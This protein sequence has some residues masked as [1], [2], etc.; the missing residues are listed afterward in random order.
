MFRIVQLFAQE[1]KM[2]LPIPNSGE[3][4]NDFVSRCMINPTMKQ[5]FSDNDQRLAVCFR[6]FKKPT[7]KEFQYEVLKKLLGV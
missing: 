4:Q 1:K 6:Q 3:S 7:S 5:D 2:P